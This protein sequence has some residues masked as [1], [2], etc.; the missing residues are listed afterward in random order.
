MQKIWIVNAFTTNFK[1]GNPAGVVIF[2][3]WPTDDFLQEIATKLGFS[4]SAFIVGKNNS[5][6][7]R[8]FTPESEAPLCGHATIAATKI[9]IEEK[10]ANPSEQINYHSQSGSITC[11]M[12][13]GWLTLDFPKYPVIEQPFTPEHLSLNIPSPDF[14]GIAENCLFASFN[15]PDDLLELNPNLEYLATFS[16]RALIAT[17]PSHLEGFDFNSR[18]FAP[19]VGIDEDPVCASAHCRLVPFWAEKLN[20]NEL[21]A[22]QASERSGILKCT[23][24]NDRVLISGEAVTVFK[25]NLDF[26]QLRDLKNVA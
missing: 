22:Y 20:K 24:L 4:N 16:Q 11:M 21:M 14:F 7:I 3:E 19:K 1:E 26:N 8:W 12:N 18:Y 13:N 9:L 23:N 17:S 25:G 10:L 15:S 2:D 5:Y 6:H